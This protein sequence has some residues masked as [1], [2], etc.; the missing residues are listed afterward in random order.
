MGHRQ[1]R[2]S[3]DKLPNILLARCLQYETIIDRCR[4]D[5][6]NSF[7]IVKSNKKKNKK[8]KQSHRAKLD[9]TLG[10]SGHRSTNYFIISRFPAND[11]MKYDFDRFLRPF[12]LRLR[13]KPKTPGNS[14]IFVVVVV[15]YQGG[16]KI[17]LRRW[18]LK[19]EKKNKNFTGVKNASFRT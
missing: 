8:K 11:G 4:P 6:A 15:V 12:S 10:L 7:P 19:N 13:G 3:G 5:S 1:D 9:R 16:L 14:I 18:R 17:K 2:R